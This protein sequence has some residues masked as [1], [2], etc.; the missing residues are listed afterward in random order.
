[1]ESNWNDSKSFK[2]N[3]IENLESATPGQ[4]KKRGRPKKS[5]EVTPVQK[6]PILKESPKFDHKTL[7]EACL[8]VLAIFDDLQTSPPKYE[9]FDDLFENDP[10][11]EQNISQKENKIVFN[12]VKHRELQLCAAKAKAAILIRKD[13]SEGL[14]DK[15]HESTLKM[16]PKGD[17]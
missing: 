15:N 3:E 10:K 11:V 13:Y 9:N 4:P 7:N 12:A 17:F 8:D 2:N 16:E 5:T 1:L 6:S 14:K